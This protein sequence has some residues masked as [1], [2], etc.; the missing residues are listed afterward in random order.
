MYLMKRVQAVMVAVLVLVLAAPAWAAKGYARPELLMETDELAK[1]VSQSN[2]RLVDAVD[3]GTYNRAHIPGAVNIFYQLLATLKT[4]KENGYP[5]SPKDAEKI[6]GEAGIDNNTLVVV[7]DGGEGPI[8]S[9]VWFALDFFGHKNVKVLNGGF[10]KWVKEGRPVTQDVAKVEKK[11]FTA[12]VPQPEK[13]IAL[14]GVKKRDKN[15]V[16]A[17]TRSFKEFI[18]QDLV[19]GAA[20]GGHIPGAVH[21]EWTQFA[22]NLET[23]K[24]ADDIKKALEKKG[25]TK[26]TKAVTY[27]QIGLGRSTMMALAMKLVGYDNVREYSG[28]WEEWSA[29][30]RLPLEK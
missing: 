6:F 8:A 28:S 5:A 7:Y 27:C 26:D 10:R 11:K 19:P 22:D 4:R 3:P 24:S 15:T 21:L 16:L 2:V 9:A 1:I 29:D 14:E 18:G 23:F 25:I 20:R 13:V 30:P 17:D 12:V